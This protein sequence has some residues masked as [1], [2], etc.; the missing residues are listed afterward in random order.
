LKDAL[1]KVKTVEKIDVSALQIVGHGKYGDIYLYP[2]EDGK[3][4]ILK[5]M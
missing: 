3:D 2:S 5:V 1:K 4:K